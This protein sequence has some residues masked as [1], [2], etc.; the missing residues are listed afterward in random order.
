MTRNTRLGSRS[1]R[2][3]PVVTPAFEE[4]CPSQRIARSRLRVD[5][6]RGH[7]RLALQRDD[8]EGIAASR[9]RLSRNPLGSAAGYGVPGLPI[10]REATRRTLGVTEGCAT[11]SPSS[12]VFQ[13]QGTHWNSS[14][15]LPEA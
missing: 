1:A 2:K 12:I 7:R 8:A 3:A 9:R 10:D 6:H 4:A 11:A 14:S 13:V 5:H 15:F